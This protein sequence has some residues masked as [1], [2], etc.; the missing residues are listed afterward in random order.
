MYSC[1]LSWNSIKETL[2][3]LSAKGYVDE[4]QTAI[5][6]I[7]NQVFSDSIQDVYIEEI[8]GRDAKSMRDVLEYFLNSG[9]EIE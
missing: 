6:L 9:I 3:L 4:E 2:D 7:L 8:K 1:N 5:V